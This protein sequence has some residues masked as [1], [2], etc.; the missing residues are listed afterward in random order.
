MVVY[1]RMFHDSRPFFFFKHFRFL[2]YYVTLRGKKGLSLLTLQT[3]MK[4]NNGMHISGVA[5]SR[6]AIAEDDDD[7]VDLPNTMICFSFEKIYSIVTLVLRK[8]KLG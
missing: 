3:V 8:Q 6:P 4:I 7:P 5:I 1:P 2:P